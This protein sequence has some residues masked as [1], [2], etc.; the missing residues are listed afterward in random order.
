MTMRLSLPLLAVLM[1][2][3]C[4]SSAPPANTAAWSVTKGRPQLLSGELARGGG[5]KEALARSYLAENAA[6]FH[7]DAPGSSLQLSTTREGL[8]GTYLRFAQYQQIARENL[9]VWDGEVIVLVAGDLVR[10]VN[11]SHK[12]EAHLAVMPEQQ[13][14]LTEATQR[15]RT[16][17]ELPADADV[18]AER[19]VYVNRDGEARVAWKFT[20][21]TEEPA[22][23][24]SLLLDVGSLL[25]LE[26]RDGVKRIDGTGY[27]FDVN[28]IAST[29]DLTLTD[30][31]NQATAQLDAARFLVTLPRLDGSGFTRGDFADVRSRDAGARANSP[32]NEFL[33]SRN[34]LGFEQA[35]VYFHLTRSQARIQA[36]GFTDVNN[37]VQGATVDQQNADNSFYSPQTLRLGFGTGGV[38]DAED[39]DI[40]MHE[41]GHAIQDN[42]VPGWGGGDEDA[43]GEGFGDYLAASFS[44]AL[45]PDAGH[46]QLSDPACVGDWDAVAYSNDT[47]PCLRRVDTTKHWPEDAE[48][49]IHAD[50]EIWSASLWRAR[51]LFGADVVDTLVLESHFILGTG[52]SFFEASE[53]LMNANTM[54]DAGADPDVLRRTLISYGVSRK[55]SQAGDGGVALSLPVSI[56]PVR[57]AVGNYRNNTDE[58]RTLT[59]PGA[60]GLRLHFE[61]VVLETSN[62]CVSRSCD[63]LYLFNAAGDLFQVVTGVQDAG[64]TSVIIP[65]ETVNVRLISDATQVR[66]GYRVDRI[67]VIGDVLDAG[68]IFDGGMDPIPQPPMDAGVPDAGRPD[69]GMQPIDAGVTSDAGVTPP[70]TSPALGEETLSP[71]V[72]RGCGCSGGEAALMLPLLLVL[73]GVR[74]RVN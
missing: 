46:P 9:K 33:Y 31:M 1:I 48:Y 61:R 42:Q 59:V 68:L 27:V 5:S 6:R 7:L 30:S 49:Q 72:N 10:A 8:A 23:D 35:N 58:T 38:D 4:E 62:D 32:T 17:L 57:D 41:Y 2:S 66:F 39:G 74:R 11:L 52:A 43:M 25:E 63:N 15:A 69:A 54:L 14:S 29:G 12:D 60:S 53:A 67:D 50:G 18:A 36:L 16:L 47:P 20:A 22:H 28:P 51:S 56:G 65:G 44:L 26:R 13:P 19:V 73:L 40:V 55:L 37:R 64:V 70:R 45:A 21:S 24:W 3:A 34:N 71:M